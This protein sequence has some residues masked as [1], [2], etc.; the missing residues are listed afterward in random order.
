MH[1]FMDW[2]RIELLLCINM[3]LSQTRTVYWW[4]L[5]II[6]FKKSCGIFSLQFKKLTQGFFIIHIRPILCCY[7]FKAII[8][9]ELDYTDTL[10]DA[11]ILR[12]VQ[13]VAKYITVSYRIDNVCILAVRVSL[14]LSIV[15]RLSLGCWTHERYISIDVDKLIW[16][17]MTNFIKYT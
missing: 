4:I 16:S 3:K 1:S 17:Y 9:A 11:K 2:H 10:L 5:S 6:Y 15:C 7:V 12:S 13:F 8:G 14:S